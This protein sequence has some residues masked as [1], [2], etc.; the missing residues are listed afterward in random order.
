MVRH[1]RHVPETKEPRWRGDKK[2]HTMKSCYWSFFAV[3]LIGCRSAPLTYSGGD[4]SSYAQAVVIKNA[5]H[6]EIGV[7]AERAW[8]EQ[9]YPRYDKEEQAL[10]TVNGKQYDLIKF[11]T[12]TGEHKSVY[13]DITGFFG[14]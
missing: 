2:Q 7:P 1:H 9:R 4:G 8:L 11:T 3:I 6:E 5:R 12:A 14:K 10:M 13:F